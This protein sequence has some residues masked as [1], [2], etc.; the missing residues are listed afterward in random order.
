MTPANVILGLKIAVIAVTLLLCASLIALARGK[1]RWHGRINIAFF[2]LTI[3]TLVGFEAVIRLIDPDLTSAFSVE[4]R[5]AL[6]IH[7]R[8]AIPAALL[9][10]VMLFTGIRRYKKVHL[11]MAACFVILWGGT[12]TTGVFFLPHSFNSVP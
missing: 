4:Q 5:E 9:L 6:A 11:A 2:G 10:P 7:L 12:F 3:A 8:F 1:P